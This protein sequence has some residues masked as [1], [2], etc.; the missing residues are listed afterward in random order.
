MVAE[1]A[2]HPSGTVSK[3]FRRPCDQ[4][5][6]YDFLENKG[7]L[8]DA[9]QAAAARATA[10]RC[11]EY[12]F[13]F[14]AVDGSSFTLTDEKQSK[15]FGSIGS[16]DRGRRG[17]KMMNALAL[18]PDGQTIG[19]LSQVFWARGAKKEKGYRV[20]ADRESVHWHQ[21]VDR[22]VKAL[23]EHAP[24]TQVHVLADREGD[25]SYLIRHLL[26]IGG[27]FTIRA[28]GNRKV[29]SQ[30]RRVLVRRHLRKTEALGTVTLELPKR[31]GVA[32]RTATLTLRAAHVEMVMRDHH[33]RHRKKVPLTVVWGL[34]E[35]A[36]EK[37]E[38]IDW[39][40]Y[41]SRSAQSAQKAAAALTQ[42]ARRWKIEEFHKMLKSG[43]GCVEDSQ[44]RSAEAVVK[45][46]T[47]HA[48]V[49]ARALRLRD[50]ARTQPEAPAST[51][52]SE[53]EIEALVVLKTMEKRKNETI[54]ADGLSMA[55]AV[56]WIGDLGGFTATGASKKMP[57]PTVIHR[58][59]ERILELVPILEALRATEKIR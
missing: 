41:T 42:Y 35:N 14:L 51:E 49:A 43:G 12:P 33:N 25:A 20:L 9:V 8:A 56:R 23:Q 22:S 11:A 53:A 34:E 16:R 45:W 36:P 1:V 52:L 46:A 7:V 21:A 13:V 6:A 31:D 28:N 17:L 32:A 50:L 44:L 18:A 54:S 58:G 48:M 40:L 29:L 15:G 30:G 57:G 2:R 38:P 27:E 37:V 19:V 4:Q 3:C 55:H 5:G 39:M 24:G 10:R 47:I 59:L 26:D